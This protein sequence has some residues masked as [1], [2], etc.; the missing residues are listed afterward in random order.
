VAFDFVTG[1]LTA[2]PDPLTIAPE[3][4]L[5]AAENIMIGANTP[6]LKKVNILDQGYAVVDATPEETIVEFR[7]LDTFDPNA[8][9]RT[10]SR[11]RVRN[12]GRT[13]ETLFSER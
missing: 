8:E 13:L 3:N 1:S 11:F 12:G 9:A 2:D 7:V 4:L 5:I 10:A 6:Y